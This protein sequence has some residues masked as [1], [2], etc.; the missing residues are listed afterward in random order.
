MIQTTSTTMHQIISFWS[1]VEKLDT[2]VYIAG[3]RGLP[4]FH[5]AEVIPTRT[6][7]P[8]LPPSLMMNP[9]PE[10]PLH[11]SLPPSLTPVQRWE[12]WIW[13][14]WW[15]L[16]AL[17]GTTWTIVKSTYHCGIESVSLCI[18]ISVPFFTVLIRKKGKASIHQNLNTYLNSCKYLQNHIVL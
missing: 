17:W 11:P 18:K 3:T 8:F 13:K 12:L 16:T 2:L 5:P 1:H 15:S 7:G 9:P 6:W 4:H 10:S 14:L